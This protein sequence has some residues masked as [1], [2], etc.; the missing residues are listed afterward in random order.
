MPETTTGAIP[1][2]NTVICEHCGMKIK[3]NAQ[4]CSACG[5]PVIVKPAKIFCQTCG[6]ELSEGERFCSNCGTSTVQSKNTEALNNIAE[7]NE[8]LNQPKSKP[9]SKLKIAA[10]AIAVIILLGVVFTVVAIPE[11]KYQ[12]ANDHQ[13]AGNYLTAY[14]MFVELGDYKKSEDEVTAT[15]LLWASHALSSED[16]WEVSSFCNTVELN[17]DHYS[18]VYST[19]VLYINNHTNAE[20]WFDYAGTTTATQNVIKMLNMLP[21]THQNTSAYLEFFNALNSE[22]SY[23]GL[24]LNR[25]TTVKKCWDL[26]L[27]KDMAEQDDAITYFLKDHWTTWDGDY[28]LELYENSSGTISSSFTLPWVAKPYGTKYYDIDDMLLYWDGDNNKHLAKVFRF[29][30]VDYD[31]IKVFCYRN[32]RTYTLYR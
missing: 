3:A 5:N 1:T 4:F 14:N 24:F 28:Y 19:T 8:S 25:A 15:V 20:Y 11:I 2:E 21:I 9:K 27:V 17:S 30:I 32:N 26:G 22:N 12:Q 13:E 18:I 31:T 23:K 10:I 6:A 16:S 7:Y 29:E